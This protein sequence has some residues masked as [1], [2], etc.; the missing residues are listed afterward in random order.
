M[1][2]EKHFKELQMI[3]VIAIKSLTSNICMTNY[4]DYKSASVKIFDI[5]NIIF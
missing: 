4:N 5:L 2:F 3:A 1:S